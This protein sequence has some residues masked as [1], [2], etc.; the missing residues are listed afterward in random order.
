MVWLLFLSFI[1]LIMSSQVLMKVRIAGKGDKIH[2][3]LQFL[4]F[5]GFLRLEQRGRLLDGG[6]YFRGGGDGERLYWLIKNGP[7]FLR[8]LPL[9][10][11]QLVDLHLFLSINLLGDPA[12]TGIA[13]GLLYSVFG[14]L[15]GFLYGSSF[16]E[17][18]FVQIKPDYHGESLVDFRGIIKTRIGYSMVTALA[19]FILILKGRGN[20]ASH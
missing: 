10:H 5:F 1:L 4:L 19:F 12:L 2:F 3:S 13:T 9:L 8:V 20:H 15:E 6:G 14:V 17:R 16:I 18:P 11:L 7:L